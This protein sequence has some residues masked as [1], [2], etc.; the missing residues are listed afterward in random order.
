MSEKCFHCKRSL[1]KKAKVKVDGKMYCMMCNEKIKKGEF[2]TI[3]LKE[4]INDLTNKPNKEKNE[5]CKCNNGNCQN[6]TNSKSEQMANDFIKTFKEYNGTKN[7]S[8]QITNGFSNVQAYFINENGAETKIYQNNIKVLCHEELLKSIMKSIFEQ[9]IRED[10][11]RKNELNKELEKE[12][13]NIQEQIE[14]NKKEME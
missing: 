11:F 2:K 7:I 12:L 14:K 9:Q 13:N 5:K 10:K 3:S 4:A 6:K 1:N 8:I